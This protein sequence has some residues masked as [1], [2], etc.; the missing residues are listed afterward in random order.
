VRKRFSDVFFCRKIC[1]GITL[2]EMRHGEI[3]ASRILPNYVSNS[4]MSADSPERKEPLG[5]N[6]TGG[7]GQYQAMKKRRPSDSTIFI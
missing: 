1:D 2:D 5:E 3:H 7:F 6:I 4:A